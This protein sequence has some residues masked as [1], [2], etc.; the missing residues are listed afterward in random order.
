M[1]EFNEGDK[2]IR[3]RSPHTR[4]ESPMTLGSEWTVDAVEGRSWF[5][6]EGYHQSLYAGYFEL[7]T[8]APL[9][10]SK[11]K[12]GDTVTLEREDGTLIRAKVFDVDPVVVNPPERTLRLYGIPDWVLI[13]KDSY[14]LT[15]HQPAPKPELPTKPGSIV[16]SQRGDEA[17]LIADP[18][19]YLPAKW[20][21]VLN[22]LYT[23]PADWPHG[24]TLVRDAG[25]DAS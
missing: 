6:V 16:K 21:W 14:A 25:K 20:Q 18:S 3:V 12:A 7:V 5:R 24:W 2:V 13:G 17:V 11:V 10:P 9:D 23:H 1:A 19:V 15:D 22:G 4:D 8:P